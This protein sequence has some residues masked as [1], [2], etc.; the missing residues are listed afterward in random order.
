MKRL[1]VDW[2]TVW[3]YATAATAISYVICWVSVAGFWMPFI[4]VMGVL[5]ANGGIA[6]WVED[7]PGGINNPPPPEKNSTPEPTDQ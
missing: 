7:Q 6:E 2:R 1:N 5:L 4:A 3:L